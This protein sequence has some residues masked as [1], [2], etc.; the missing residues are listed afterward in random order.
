MKPSQLPWIWLLFSLL[1]VLAFG[2]ALI[3]KLIGDTSRFGDRVAA[4]LS[5]WTGGEVKFIGPVRVTF[6]PDVSVRGQLEVQDSTRLPAVQVLAAR[7]AKVSLDLVDLLRGTVTI[8]ALRLLKPRIIL[9]DGPMAGLLQGQAP[10]TLF[11]NLLSGA[12]MRVLDVRKGRI[13]LGPR[14]SSI[15]EIYAHLDAGKGTGAI[16]GFGAFTYKDT[17]VRY[18]LESQAPTNVGAVG[19]FPL[20]LTLTSKPI[21]ARLNGTVSYAGELKLDGDMRAEIDDAR[22][23]LNWVGLSLPGGDSLKGFSAAGAFH[24]AGPTLTFDNGTFTLDD[25]KAVGLLALTATGSRP[26]VEGTLAFDRLV[27]D[28]YLGNTDQTE[29]K[30][31]SPASTGGLPFGGLL[32]QFIDADLRIS[33]A[34]IDAGALKLGRGGF[35]VTAKK[36]VVA[37]EVGELELCGGSADGRL[38]V[39]LAQAPPQ[40][41][42]VANLAD[43]SM[44]ACLQ[45][46][47]LAVPIKGTSRLKTE[48]ATEG[49]D[50]AQLTGNLT[51]TLKV[52]ANDGVVPVDFAHLVTGTAPLN[53]EGWSGDSVTP[54]DQ[55]D[56]DCRLSAGHIWCQSLSMRT[57]RG[58]IS[59]A[60]GV[61]LTKQ[62]LDWNLTV[63]NPVIPATASQLTQEEAPS[64]SIRGSLSQPMIRRADRPTLGEGGL[65][66]S[67]EGPQ[68]LPH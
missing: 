25:N 52:D 42:V 9:R 61:D 27:L 18:S 3:P 49:S 36:G 53:G 15:K 5:S 44:D 39:D 4:E 62:T 60:G 41:N 1:A 46:L 67:P 21:R 35:T 20:T 66:M 14:G 43:V 40:V 10:Q 17:T 32:L 12:P 38:N 6:F 37:S 48:L 2:I 8:G 63:A 11:T 50:L 47:G 22:K 64:V 31:A 33:A 16:S 29:S 65:Q 23:F 19:S 24:V 55:L 59:G 45:P 13:A 58:D 34:A 30:Q 26:R 54:F 57:P 51:G 7:E 68:V 56:A 28:P